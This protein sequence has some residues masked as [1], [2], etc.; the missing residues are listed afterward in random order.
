MRAF[1]YRYFLAIA[2]VA[3][4]VSALS[5]VV[6]VLAGVDQAAL[7]T[8]G[9]TLASVLAFRHTRIATSLRMI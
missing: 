6:V 7:W 1:P 9:V 8:N 2:L 5:T 3:A 4:V